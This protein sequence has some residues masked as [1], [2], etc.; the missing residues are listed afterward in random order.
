MNEREALNALITD[1][2]R[3]ITEFKTRY[4]TS[5]TRLANY[6]LV[7]KLSGLRE[8][9]VAGWLAQKRRERDPEVLAVF[10]QLVRPVLR[11]V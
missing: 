11:V 3:K 5:T 7:E 4:P 6:V 10:D 8:A 9:A 2:N 1:S